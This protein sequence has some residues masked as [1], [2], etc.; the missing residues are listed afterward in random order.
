[1]LWVRNT[2]VR[3]CK[4]FFLY[5]TEWAGVS[6]IS[7][8]QLPLRDPPLLF[9]TPSKN[10]VASIAQVDSNL[11]DYSQHKLIQSRPRLRAHAS[12]LSS[13]HAGDR[14]SGRRCNSCRANYGITRA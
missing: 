1:M 2:I 7:F 14:R 12:S 9:P 11:S 6:W 10:D 5:F 3:R 8:Q 13:G 4:V